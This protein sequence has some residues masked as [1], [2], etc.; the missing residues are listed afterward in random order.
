MIPSAPISFAPWLRPMPWGGF[1]LATLLSLPASQERIGEAWLFS[2]HAQHRSQISHGV[3]AGLPLDELISRDALAC[4][5]VD[6][7]Q[8]FPLLIKI[9]DAKQNLSIQVHPDDALAV[10]WSPGEG[11]KT[12][13]W[14]VLSA[15]PGAAIYLGLKPGIDLATF[16]TE[17]AAGNAPLC[18][19]RYDP[20]PGETYFIT[21]GTVHAL[22]QGVVVLEVQQTSDA[23]FRLYDWGRVGNDGKPRTLH[24]EA[25]LACTKIS[26]E[27]AGLQQA[28]PERDGSAR[29]ISTP[30]FTMKRWENVG[31]VSIQ[32]PAILLPLNV[33]ITCVDT[34]SS[35]P[36]GQA[37]L[38]PAIMGQA[39]FSLPVD[40]VVFEIRW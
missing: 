25:G 21:A 31:E 12:E 35:V 13:A 39:R 15:E 34:Q 17:L 16:Q 5:G 7:V 8:R 2:D 11:G 26:P 14:T 10:K 37:S 23:T 36:A 28:T 30:F 29:L 24:L 19:R 9:L 4:L 20:Q 3:N 32:A 6:Q 40:A 1:K 22:G 33:P 18:L 38:I 27:R